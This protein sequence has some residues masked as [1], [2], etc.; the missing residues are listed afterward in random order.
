[1]AVYVDDMYQY[2]MGQFGRMK[3]SHLMADSTEEL[4]VMVDKI[5]VQRRWIQK[6]GTDGEHFDISIGKRREA[7]AAGAVPVTLRSLACWSH[8]KGELE[9]IVDDPHAPKELRELL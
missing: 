1:M 8:D 5:D 7:L 4:L 6:P 2:P 9:L 3:M